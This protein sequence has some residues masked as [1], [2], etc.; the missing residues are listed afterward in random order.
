MTIAIVDRIAGCLH[1]IAT[2]DAIGKQTET[3]AH[4]AVRHCWRGSR[5]R[6]RML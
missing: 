4:D 2:G 1:G 6:A 3:L 5:P